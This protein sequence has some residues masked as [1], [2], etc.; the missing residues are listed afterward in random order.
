MSASNRNFS[1]EADKIFSIA[2]NLFQ[3]SIWNRKV[4][5]L[6]PDTKF[7]PMFGSEAVWSVKSEHVFCEEGYEEDMIFYLTIG[8]WTSG[9]TLMNIK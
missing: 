6:A 4:P 3:K 2:L 1:I 5:I 7:K 8:L 9:I